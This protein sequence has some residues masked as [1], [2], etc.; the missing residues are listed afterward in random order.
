MRPADRVHVGALEVSPLCLGAVA[1]PATVERAFS[2]GINFFFISSDLHWPMYRHTRE[3]LHRLLAAGTP[4]DELVIATA[5]YVAQRDFAGASF[6]DIRHHEPGLGRIDVLV[7]GGV[8]MDDFL[9]RRAVLEAARDRGDTGAHTLGASFHD[10]AAARLAIVHE[11][12]DIAFVRY[13]A[14]HPG[15]RSDLFPGIP[16]GTGTPAYVFNATRGWVADGDTEGL[17]PDEDYWRPTITDHYRFAISTPGVAGI[18]CAPATPGELDEALEALAEGP[19][20]VESQDHMIE[21]AQLA[22]RAAQRQPK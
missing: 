8:Y 1:D 7:A 16:A 21:L 15:A 2:A 12:V 6:D 5:S 4:R 20:D 14:L 17:L 13:N 3:G 10:R 11:L 9:A 19:L 22:A 18:L